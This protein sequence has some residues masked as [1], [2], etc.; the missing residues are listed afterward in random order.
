MRTTEQY[1]RGKQWL[2]KGLCKEICGYMAKFWR[3]QNEGERK[4]QW[5]SWEK[6]TRVK[7]SGGLGFRDLEHFNSAL[8]AKQLW[9]IL[10]QPAA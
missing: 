2:P 5:I 8:L 7:G 10:M 3:G 6:I 1:Q 4:M 9:R